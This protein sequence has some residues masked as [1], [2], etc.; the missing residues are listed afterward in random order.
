[1]D[2]DEGVVAQEFKPSQN[3]SY[4]MS[5]HQIFKMK[6]VFDAFDTDFDGIMSMEF[7]G[8]AMRASGLLIG[9]QEI[10]DTKKALSDEG[11]VGSIEM[12]RFFLLMAVKLRDAGENAEK[13]AYTA[14]KSIYNDPEDP[15]T[16]FIP[17]KV[18]RMKLSASGGEAFTEE[19]MD[20]FLKEVPAEVLNADGSKADFDA[21]I[22]WVMRDLPELKDEEERKTEEGVEKDEGLEVGDDE[23]GEGGEGAGDEG[24]AKAEDAVAGGGKS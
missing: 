15:L 11:V 8:Q 24:D 1:M 5:K 12:G 2:E 16:K 22:D 6:Q 17:L 18:L 19:Q 3:F 23:E 7:L 4:R 14:F 20:A 13:A 9:N 10:E 21:F